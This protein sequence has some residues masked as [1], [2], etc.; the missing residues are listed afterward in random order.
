MIVLFGDLSSPLQPDLEM[1]LSLWIKYTPSH[2]VK[3][4]HYTFK[5]IFFA[6][7]LQK[8]KICCSFWARQTSYEF[9]Y[10]STYFD[11]ICIS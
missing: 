4:L 6:C 2:F 7:E 8:Y 9:Q 10:C 11:F 3:K 1:S 5:F